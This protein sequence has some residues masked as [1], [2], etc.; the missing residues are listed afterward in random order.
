MKLEKALAEYKA[1]VHAQGLE[2]KTVQNRVQP[3]K[4]CLEVWGNVEVSEIHSSHINQFFEHKEFATRT[5][6][7]YLGHLNKF[8]EWAQYEDYMGKKNPTFGWRMGKVPESTKL[9]IPVERFSELLDTPE[10]A[11]DRAALALGLY[12]F[13]RGSEMRTITIGDLDLGAGRIFVKR[14]KTKGE[15]AIPICSELAEEMATWL[16][17]YRKECDGLMPGWFLI[18]AK[19][20]NTWGM[21]A[22]P[23]GSYLW[24]E[25][26]ASGRLRPSTKVSHPYRIVQRTLRDMDFDIDRL[27]EGYHTLRRSGARALFDTLRAEGN[28]SALLR[29]GSMLGHKD[30]KVTTEYIGLKMEREQ[31]DAL[32]AGQ[33]MFPGQKM[34]KGLRAVG[35]E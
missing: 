29:V 3:I 32:I 31:R 8:F 14:W 19:G 6:N 22:Q 28:D 30:T 10:H 34:V 35:G 20:P 12:T 21:V 13:I 5:R 15:D 7:L 1:H 25:R 27:G 26:G 16:N 9:R 18:P 4:K 2:P 23:D 33:P 24:Q 17:Y 11:R